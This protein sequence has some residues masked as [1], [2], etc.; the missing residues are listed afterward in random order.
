MITKYL[1]RTKR[2]ALRALSRKVC[3]DEITEKLLKVGVELGNDIYVT[4]SLSSFGNLERGVDTLLQGL[5]SVAG[6]EG[7]ILAPGHSNPSTLDTQ[8]IDLR[9]HNMNT[10]V[11]PSHLMSQLGSLRSSHPFAS[12]ICLGPKSTYYT[13]GHEDFPTICH[14]N[15]P[16]A[17]VYYNDAYLIGFGT[18][19]TAM[20]HYHLIEEAR[21]DYPLNVYNQGVCVEYK[22]FQGKRIKREIKTFQ[23]PLNEYRIERPRGKK[24]RKDFLIKMRKSKTFHE[25]KIGRCKAWAIK[26]KNL[27]SI[28]EDWLDE[29]CTIY[30][31][32]RYTDNEKDTIPFTRPF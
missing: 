7:T 21:V 1:R 6:S 28:I 9:C 15:S 5:I 24:V 20:I 8:G 26:S 30:D 19:P 10:G 4:S 14:E 22:N 11:F 32:K 23:S 16:V 31:L 3:S 12:T 13:S 17:K 2:S 25:F 29:G 18:E 27:Y